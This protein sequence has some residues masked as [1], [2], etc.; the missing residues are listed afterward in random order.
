M[1]RTKD[2]V[3]KL[4]LTIVC[5]KLEK[6]MRMRAKMTKNEAK[7]T[8]RVLAEDADEGKIMETVVRPICS[9]QYQGRWFT[10]VEVEIITG[11]THQIRA[12]LAQ[13]GF[14]VIGDIKY[15]D[16][17]YN[18]FVQD[19]FG[20]STQL[21]HAYKLMFT[22]QAL[23][24][25]T[26][27]TAELPNGAGPKAQ[28]EAQAAQGSGLLSYLAG[29]TITAELPPDFARIKTSIFGNDKEEIEK[30]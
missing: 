13:A 5:G 21:L 16:R 28:S 19:R 4:Y 1:I 7:N 24:A 2:A 18:R 20:L 6:S 14:P 22:Q 9:A 15:G 17:A 29:K 23:K 12:H 11:R 27:E 10:L 26:A 8:V 3:R 30:K 25:Q